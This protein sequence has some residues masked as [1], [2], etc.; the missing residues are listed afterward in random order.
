MRKIVITGASSAIGLAISRKLITPIDTCL[1]HCF[2]NQDGLAAEKERLG[3]NCQIITADFTNQAALKAFCRQLEDTDILINLAAAT[4][5][6]LLVNL[7]PEDIM[8]MLQ[9][10]AG[11]TALLCRAAV[12]SMAVRRSG[13]IINF[14]SV[15]AQRGVKGQTVYA[16]TKGFIESFTRALA[17][18]YGP[19][20]IRAN[21]IAPGPIDA[22]SLTELLN[23]APAEVRQS[24]SLPRLGTPEDAANAAVFLCSDA[25]SFISGSVLNVGGG[26]CR[27]V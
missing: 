14:S 22:G 19:R 20:G 24:I 10:N 1:L 3:D 7:S 16:G 12:R 2:H 21:C 15:A 26:Y 11:A 8:L 9:V 27:G 25:A 23:L 4:I 5:T 13:I 18:E 6:D 17:A